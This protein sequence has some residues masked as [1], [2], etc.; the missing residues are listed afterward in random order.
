MKQFLFG[1]ALGVLLLAAAF[2]GATYWPEVQDYAKQHGLITKT[3]EE[4]FAEFKQQL[5]K[6]ENYGRVGGAYKQDLAGSNIVITIGTEAVR[7]TLIDPYN[8][9]IRGAFVTH[10]PKTGYVH[11]CG[12]LNAKN[13]FGGYTGEQ[14]F[15]IKVDLA[16]TI[17]HSKG[18]RPTF[19]NEVPGEYRDYLARLE[20]RPGR[21]FQAACGLGFSVEMLRATM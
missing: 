19:I 2:F 20:G 3:D 17:E 4:I 7:R 8:A 1:C 15:F 5:A 9:K 11:V 13:A 10:D 14:P 6:S 21:L 16:S 12:F 18:R